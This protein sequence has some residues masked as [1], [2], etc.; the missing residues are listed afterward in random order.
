MAQTI[1][2]KINSAK[3]ERG[4]KKI[5]ID[6]LDGKKLVLVSKYVAGLVSVL[7]KLLSDR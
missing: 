2:Q 4:K 6:D 5:E 1:N 7:K 3:N